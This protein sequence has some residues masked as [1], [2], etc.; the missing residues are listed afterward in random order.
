[1]KHQSLLKKLKLFSLYKKEITNLEI[2]L[3]TK[4]NARVDRAYRVYTVLNIPTDVVEEPYNIRKTDID[5]IAKTYIK[6]YSSQL[7]KLLNNRGL[8]ELFSFYQTKKV[9]KGCLILNAADGEGKVVLSVDN[10]NYDA[11]Y[12]IKYFL[13]IKYPDDSNQHT[14]NYIEM[15]REFSKEVMQPQ[16][17]MQEQ[18]SFLAKTVDFFKENGIH[19]IISRPAIP[20]A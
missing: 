17:G 16:F 19:A 13:N 1:M 9:D 5:N 15:C 18:S 2:E 7:S 10:N 14:K 8:M 4:L 3:A 11:Q 20:F 12:W 6:E